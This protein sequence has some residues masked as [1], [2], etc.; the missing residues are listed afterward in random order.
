MPRNSDELTAEQEAA[1]V[2]DFLVASG[3]AAQL[4]ITSPACVTQITLFHDGGNNDRGCSPRPISIVV[5][6]T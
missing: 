3:L 5:P 1:A 2:R 4:R 6:D